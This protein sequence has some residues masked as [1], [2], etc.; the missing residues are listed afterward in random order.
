MPEEIERLT[1]TE[2]ELLEGSGLLH[3]HSVP[4]TYKIHTHDFYELFL[5]P[6]GKA[7]HQ[8]NGGNQFLTEGSFVLM[9][10]DDVHKYDFFN[11]YDFEIMNLGI[12]QSLFHEIL[13]Y[14][15]LDGE[16]ITSAALPPHVVLSG[17][18]L[19]DVKW[20]LLQ[21]TKMKEFK[22]RY[23]ISAPCCRG[24]CTYFMTATWHRRKG[25]L[26]QDGL[27]ICWKI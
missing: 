17:Y 8:V 15:M 19:S 4:E 9:R 2:K 1:M 13:A 14:T 18:I 7:I 27:R 25:G 10:P 11:N 23:A 22:L 16:R 20:K 12:P 26:C 21:I 24:F 3:Q 5:V 6:K